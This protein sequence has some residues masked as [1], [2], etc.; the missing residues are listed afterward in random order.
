MFHRVEIR[1]TGSDMASPMG[2]M[3]SWL[4]RHHV[5]SATFEHSSAGTCTTFRIW[6]NGEAQA[7]AFADAFGGRLSHGTDPT[8][9]ALSEAILPLR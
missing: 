1:R 5:Q 4:D 9:P 7:K 2:E 6:F 3:R 8:A